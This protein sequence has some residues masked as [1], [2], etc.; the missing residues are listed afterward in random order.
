MEGAESFD[1]QESISYEE[2]KE[3][4]NFMSKYKMVDG[5]CVEKDEEDKSLKDD[6]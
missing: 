1:R 4:E 5:F 3:I 6:N 2:R